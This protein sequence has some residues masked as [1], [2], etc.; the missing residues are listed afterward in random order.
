MAALSQADIVNRAVQLVGG[1]NN[2]A[3]VTGSAPTFDGSVI[4]LAAGTIYNEVVQAVGREFGFDF[5]RNTA[6]LV[7]TGNTP[8]APWSQEYLYPA[9]AVQ[10][11]EIMPDTIVDPN[12][13]LP[14]N[15]TV[16]NALVAA[17]PT[18][19]IWTNLADAQAI[20]SN[21]PPEA[22]WD[23]LFAEAVV[24]MLGARLEMATA[25]RPDTMKAVMEM[26][27]ST[28]QVATGRDG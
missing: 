6:D 26:G 9:S 17:V 19:V 24:Q 23:P 3:P 18:K 13:P 2:N 22:L 4:G 14:T 15:W 5:S 11:R 25:G 8:P 21:T 16:G 28:T 27:A 1:Y 7:P 10:V 12:D 20:I